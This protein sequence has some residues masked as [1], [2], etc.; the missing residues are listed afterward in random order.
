MDS[1]CSP[2]RKGSGLREVESACAVFVTKMSGEDY[3]KID[4]ILQHGPLRHERFRSNARR[5]TSPIIS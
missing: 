2:R 3:A 1:D 5:P 4:E